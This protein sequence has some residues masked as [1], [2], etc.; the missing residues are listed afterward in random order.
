MIDVRLLCTK[1]QFGIDLP[2]NMEMT[3]GNRT[4]EVLGLAK[5]EYRDDIIWQWWIVCCYDETE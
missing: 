1:T 3:L 4:M 2:L 5:Q